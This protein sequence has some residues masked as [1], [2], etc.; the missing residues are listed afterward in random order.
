MSSIRLAITAL[1]L[2]FPLLLIAC[3]DD[4][5]VGDATPSPD[6]TPAVNGTPPSTP[7]PD[8]GTPLGRQTGGATCDSLFPD[9]EPDVGQT[10]ED[11]FVCIAEPEPG[12]MVGGDIEVRGFQAGAF[13][14][15]VEIELRGSDGAVLAADFT[16]ANAPDIGL[17]V[18][19]WTATLT[20][21]NTAP[22]GDGTIAAFSRS[23][24]DGS[25]DFGGEIPVTIEE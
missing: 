11:V 14:Q 22:L 21:P 3:D 25:I 16:T 7:G 23:P 6:Q 12:A 4:D 5:D 2:L 15:N 19:E 9:E 8:A 10:V 20:V 13:E 1:V 24:R 18:G 17:V